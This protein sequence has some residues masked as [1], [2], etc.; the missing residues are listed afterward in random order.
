[1]SGPWGSEGGV[2]DDTFVHRLRELLGDNPSMADEQFSPTGTATKFVCTKLPVN[3]DRYVVLTNL[4]VPVPIVTSRTSIPSNSAF[5]DYDTGL[6]VFGTPPGVGTNTVVIQKSRVRWRD[7][8]LLN[9]LYDGL[10]S[11]YPQCWK[12][13]VDQSIGIAV[14]TFDYTMPPDFYD[15]RCRIMRVSVR[16]IPAQTNVF[17]IIAGATRVGL[18]TIRIPASQYWSPTSSIEVQY[19]APYRSLSELQPQ[20]MDYP[21]WYAAGKILGFG[22]VGRTR[23]D[24]QTVASSTSA[25]PNGAQQNAGGF[26]MSQ[27]AKLLANLARPMGMSR[28]ISTYSR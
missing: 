28:P 22:E 1:M 4:G 2:D 27:A 20:E 12:E 19:A 6:I 21:T 14:N 13:A 8:T 10:R 3:D 7:S 25:S 24:N 5:V 9:A 11:M 23:V 17:K 15:P 18:D 26:F 16:E